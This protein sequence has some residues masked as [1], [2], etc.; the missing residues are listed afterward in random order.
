MQCNEYSVSQQNLQRVVVGQLLKEIGRS[1][2]DEVGEDDVASSVE[3]SRI[4]FSA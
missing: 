4:K 3:D 1:G 2:G